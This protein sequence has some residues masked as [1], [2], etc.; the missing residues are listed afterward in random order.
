MWARVKGFS[1]IPLWMAHIK[2]QVKF[3]IA[4]L[5]VLGAPKGMRRR[6]GPDSTP[7]ALTK[8]ILS[9]IMRQEYSYLQCDQETEVTKYRMWVTQSLLSPG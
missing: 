1:H 7:V 8:W 5:P 2:V 9:L 6:Q 4:A 3:Q